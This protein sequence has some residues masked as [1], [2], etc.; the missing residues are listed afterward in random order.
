MNRNILFAVIFFISINQK[1]R[2]QQNVSLVTAD[3]DH[4]WVAYDKI[5]ATKDTVAQYAYLNN[6]FIQKGTP[7]LKAMMQARSYTAK[8][9]ID[10]IS[11][12]QAYFNSIR[13][14]TLRVNDYATAI[15]SKISILKQLYP[16]L[17]PAE[18]YFTIGAFRSGGTT[19]GNMV[20]IGSEIAMD[21]EHLDN[22]VFTNIH[23][24]VHTQQKTSMGDNLL[25]QC[26]LEGVAEFISEQAMST[27]STL[28]ALAFGKSNPVTVKQDFATQMFNTG[29]GFWLYSNAENQFGVRD[30]GYYVGYAIAQRYH[31]NTIDKTK[32]IKEMIELDYNNMEALYNYVD[33]S[34]YFDKKVK[35]LKRAY[36][37]NR[38][39]VINGIVTK[40]EHEIDSLNYKITVKFSKPMDKRYRSFEQGPLGQDSSMRIKK[41]IGFSEDGKSAEFEVELK[42]NKRYQLVIGEGFRDL[43]GARIKP[44]LI[45]FKT[46]NE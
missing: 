27:H 35:S 21:D 42:P 39:S 43:N 2:A 17:K 19:L 28:P 15:A 46:G 20:L 13:K 26:V 22:L 1:V 44:Y 10:A 4:F 8:S 7:G 33:Q 6:L 37:K 9:Y 5:I 41:V 23:E 45:D 38:P 25:A 32:A 30:L 14:N 12:K 16:A 34:G 18:I 40:S 11:Q 24:Y 31:L 3:I 29:N 36:E